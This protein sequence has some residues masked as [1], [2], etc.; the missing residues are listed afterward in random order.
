M[1]EK[2]KG[3]RNIYFHKNLPDPV[4][5]AEYNLSGAEAKIFWYVAI[6]CHVNPETNYTKATNDQL[7]FIL[8]M[9]KSTVKTSVSNLVKM[10]L[11]KTRLY[12]NK[13]GS[14]GF[15]NDRRIYINPEITATFTNEKTDLVYA[16][17]QEDC[18]D[19]S[20]NERYFMA[21]ERRKKLLSKPEPKE[22]VEDIPDDEDDLSSLSPE[23]RAAKIDEE[24]LEF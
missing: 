23:E 10:G 6:Q 1:A 19:R 9:A 2:K 8:C 18:T 3:Y 16:P 17:H 7:A 12:R 21:V 14:N 22:I 4:R 13:V 5:L 24:G 15:F 11:I 20:I